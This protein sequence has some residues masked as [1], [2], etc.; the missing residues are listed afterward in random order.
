MKYGLGLRDIKLQ[1]P[2]QVIDVTGNELTLSHSFI[3]LIADGSSE[4]TLCNF[5]QNFFQTRGQIKKTAKIKKLFCTSML[6][7]Q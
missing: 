1:L 5:A 7:L 6:N 2:L 4:Q 3:I